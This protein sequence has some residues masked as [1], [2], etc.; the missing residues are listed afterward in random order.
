MIKAMQAL[1][2]NYQHHHCW[3]GLCPGFVVVLAIASLPYSYPF[4][5]PDSV[6][7]LEYFE[8]PVFLLNPLSILCI[9]EA[10]TEIGISNYKP[11]TFQEIK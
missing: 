10:D 3:T 11:M 5:M 8:L 1:A 4:P 7:F 6:P 2:A 9:Q